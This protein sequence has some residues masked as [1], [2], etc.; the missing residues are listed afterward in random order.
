[1]NT[2]D[3]II[4]KTKGLPEEALQEILDFIEFIKQKKVKKS[5]KDNIGYELSNLDNT[6][7]NHLEEEFKDY[8]EI[9]PHAK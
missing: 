4:E 5:I 9:Y 1:M 8:K 7:T 3:Y 6:E 2:L